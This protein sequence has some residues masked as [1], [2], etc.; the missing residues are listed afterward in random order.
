[1]YSIVAI[2]FSNTGYSVN[3]TGG[4]INLPVNVIRL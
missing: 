1:M 2:K 3:S 4:A